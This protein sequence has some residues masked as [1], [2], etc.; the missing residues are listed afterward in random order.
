MKIVNISNRIN[1]EFEVRKQID[2]TTEVVLDAQVMKMSHEL[3]RSAINKMGQIEFSDDEYFN[4]LVSTGILYKVTRYVT[5][6]RW[7]KCN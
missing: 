2:N 6:G 1:S 5:K 3:M 7:P 4:V